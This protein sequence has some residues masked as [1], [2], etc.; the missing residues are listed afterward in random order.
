MKN[1][2]SEF[3]KS[4]GGST[5]Y[6]GETKTMYIRFL[7]CKRPE[8]KLTLSQLHKRVINRFGYGLTFKLA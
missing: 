7:K 2:V 5:H 6:S 8:L 1:K 3:V 4:M